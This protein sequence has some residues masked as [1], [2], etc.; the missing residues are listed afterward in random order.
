MAEDKRFNWR[1]PL[2]GAVGALT[3]FLPNLLTGADLG[4]ILYLFVAAPFVSLVL[5]FV[6]MRNGGRQPLP[7]LSMLIVYCVIS[8]GLFKNQSDLRDLGRWVLGSRNYKAE[9]LSQPT[10]TNGELKHLE[11][12]GS[13]F[14]GI[15]NRS[16]YLIFDPNDSLAQETRNHS[17]HKFTGIPCEVPR[18]IRLESHWYSVE[19]YTDTN[20]EHCN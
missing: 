17:S 14:A 12:D 20:W 2:Y 13:G 4:L 3:V 7:V 1:L 5:I 18:L 19:F 11:W 10:P 9:V 16:V 6:A 15:A 8:W